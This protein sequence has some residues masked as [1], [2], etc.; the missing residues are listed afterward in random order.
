MSLVVVTPPD[1]EVAWV[2]AEGRV[3]RATSAMNLAFVELVDTMVDLLAR[4]GWTGWGI[5]SPEHWLSWKGQQ[6][7]R[8][9]EGIVAVARRVGELPECW[10]LCR[11]GKVTEEAMVRIARRVP[12]SH[13]G[14]V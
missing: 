13:D 8:R 6:S 11:A 4:E 14:Q 1:S 7:R 2:E 5:Q 12:G 9:A 10:A 3:A